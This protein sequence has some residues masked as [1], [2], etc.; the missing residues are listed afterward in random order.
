MVPRLAEEKENDER[1]PTDRLPKA[2]GILGITPR[3][4]QAAI[5]SRRP[6]GPED[7]EATQK[8]TKLIYNKS[9]EILR[10]AE[11]FRRRK[12]RRVVAS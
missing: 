9:L 12:K 4:L 2:L 3:S 7:N 6:N 5:N 10:R 1:P 11:A 8:I